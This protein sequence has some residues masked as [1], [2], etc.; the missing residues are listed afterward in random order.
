M[1]STAGHPNMAVDTKVVRFDFRINLPNS[2][3]SEAAFQMKGVA[4]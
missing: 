4:N 3:A 1:Q 2:I